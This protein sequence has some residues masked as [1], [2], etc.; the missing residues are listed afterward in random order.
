MDFSYVNLDPVLLINKCLTFSKYSHHLK[1]EW[2]Y[3][4]I[5]RYY[6]VYVH[7]IRIY[8]FEKYLLCHLVP[9][10]GLGNK[11]PEYS[12]Y[13]VQ[14]LSTQWGTNQEILC[15]NKTQIRLSNELTFPTLFCFSPPWNLGREEIVFWVN[16]TFDQIIQMFRCSKDY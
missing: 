6:Y 10:T 4:F 3:P 7:Y 1:N 2:K 9:G 5:K 16:K 15:M 13:Q 12:E 14:A 11:C 8:S